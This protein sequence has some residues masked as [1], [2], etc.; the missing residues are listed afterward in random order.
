MALVVVAELVLLVLV[1]PVR[2]DDELAAPGAGV[3]GLRGGLRG[4]EAGEDEGQDEDAHARSLPPRALARVGEVP[5]V[6]GRRP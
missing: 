4:D 6:A 1:L 2:E 3:D 5:K